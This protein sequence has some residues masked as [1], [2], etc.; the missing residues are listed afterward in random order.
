MPSCFKTSTIVPVPKKDRITC[1][2]DYRPFALTSVI[3]KSFDRL[4]LSFL[5]PITDPLLDPLQFAYR[6]N[7]SVE[8]AINRSLHHIL[9]HLEQ[10]S[11]YVKALFVD[12]SSTFNTILP[13][14]LHTKL[15]QL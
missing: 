12:C 4:I 2:N 9:Q 14:C 15:L 11:S 7:C 10:L 8:D 1:L 6:A 5:K 3:M 13:D